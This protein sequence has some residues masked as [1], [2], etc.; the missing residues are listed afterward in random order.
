MSCISSVRYLQ[1]SLYTIQRSPISEMLNFMSS[2]S[3]HISPTSIAPTF[4]FP[5]YMLLQPFKREAPWAY[6]QVRLPHQHKMTLPAWTLDYYHLRESSGVGLGWH[7]LTALIKAI[8]IFLTA[9]NFFLSANVLFKF[10]STCTLP[11]GSW[12]DAMS[13]QI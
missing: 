8:V 6:Y 5:F 12:T 4:S 1:A 2:F 11:F 7:E 13:F 9:Y 3:D 10:L